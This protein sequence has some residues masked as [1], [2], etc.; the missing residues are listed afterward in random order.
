M[1]IKNVIL[2][3]I[4]YIIF[5]ALFHNTAFADTVNLSG[6]IIGDS[7]QPLADTTIALID[8][9]SKKTITSTTTNPNGQYYLEIPQGSYDIIIAQI[10]SGGL[11]K[12]FINQKISSNTVQNFTLAS[13][14]PLYNKNKTGFLGINLLSLAVL[15]GII[16]AICFIFWRNKNTH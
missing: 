2:F 12:T 9:V 4:S 6:M 14:P 7:G 3:L 16:L 13:K 5:G 10:S 8:T 15:G 1:N 11:K